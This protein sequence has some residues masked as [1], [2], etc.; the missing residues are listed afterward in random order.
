M[1]D[2]GRHPHMAHCLELGKLSRR[3]DQGEQARGHLTTA[4]AM[5]AK[6]A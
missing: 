3:I 4:T 1:T 2:S 6:W 5:Y